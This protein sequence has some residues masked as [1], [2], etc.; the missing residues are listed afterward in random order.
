MQVLESKEVTVG[1]QYYV[2]TAMGAM[3]GLDFM[4][5][6]PSDGGFPPAED[7][8][9]VLV[10]Y[11]KMGGK[12]FT[13]QSFDIHFSR[14]YHEIFQLFQEFFEFNFGVEVPNEMS[15]TEEDTKEK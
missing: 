15:D 8:R 14:K 4:T 13:N 3:D 10:K 1:D 12:S 2:M 11:V 6:M 9:R 7:I 5:K